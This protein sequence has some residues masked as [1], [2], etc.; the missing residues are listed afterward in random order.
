MPNKR[1]SEE[2]VEEIER[3]SRENYGP[4]YISNF[5]NIS[6]PTVKKYQDRMNQPEDQ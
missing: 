1:I 6:R 4:N 3:L 2:K 5:L